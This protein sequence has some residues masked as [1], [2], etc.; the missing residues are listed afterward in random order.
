M[1]D[2]PSSYYVCYCRSVPHTVS[3]SFNGGEIVV[4]GNC[5]EYIN[6]GLKSKWGKLFRK[7]TFL[8]YSFSHIWASTSSTL[9]R[10]VCA[11]VN[12]W[13]NLFWVIH[14]KLMQLVSKWNAIN[15][16]FSMYMWKS[17]AFMQY[18]HI[19]ED[20]E[21]GAEMNNVVKWRWLCVFSW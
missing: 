17:H 18:G 8:S 6:S 11:R 14:S 5:W 3:M 20:E 15:N 19:C 16:N 1:C 2:F 9:M 4:K 12:E 7:L 21:N 13:S 10:I